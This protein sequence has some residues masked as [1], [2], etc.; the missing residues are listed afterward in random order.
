MSSSEI[1]T[2]Q[3]KHYM[4]FLLGSADDLP[5]KLLCFN[6]SHFAY[7]ADDKLL[8]FS[9]WSQKMEFDISCW[10]SCMETICMTYQTLSSVKKKNISECRLLIFP[11]S[12]LCI[13][14]SRTV[15]SVSWWQIRIIFFP[16]SRPSIYTNCL[17]R[18]QF[19]RDARSFSS[20]K[21]YKNISKCLF[22]T[23]R[24]NLVQRILINNL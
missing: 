8:F 11:R 7:S 18:R 22:N 4:K 9:S 13:N 16:D 10:L 24:V 12:I 17:L 19:A 6:V 3:A 20:G 21:W 14:C 1:F 2:H 5:C 15:G 23:K